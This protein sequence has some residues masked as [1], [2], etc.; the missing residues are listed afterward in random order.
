MKN[1]RPEDQG[2]GGR[3]AAQRLRVQT[4]ELTDLNFNPA[5]TSSQLRDLRN[6]T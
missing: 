3:G 6:V 1:G 4:L 5:S 2:L